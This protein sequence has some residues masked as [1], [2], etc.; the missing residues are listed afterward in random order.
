M[1]LNVTIEK[2]W[3]SIYESSVGIHLFTD[4]ITSIRL[5]GERHGGTTFLTAYLKECFPNRSIEDSFVSGKH[6]M[7]ASPKYIVKAAGK[8]GEAGL[9]PSQLRNNLNGKTWWQIA[10]AAKPESEFNTTLVLAVFRNPYDWI[11]AMR[12]GPWHWPNHIEILPRN[13]SILTTVGTHKNGT[14]PTNTGGSI[15]GETF[16]KSF[17][18]KSILEWKDF[19]SRPMHFLGAER[20]YTGGLCQKG[21][22]VGAI[23]PCYRDKPYTPTSVKHIPRSFLKHLPFAA[24]DVVYELAGKGTPYEHP[25]QLRAAKIKNFLGLVQKWELGGFG[26]VRYED[27]LGERLA[28]FVWS[29]SQA[30]GEESRC[31]QLLPFT[32]PRYAI[33][34]DFRTWITEHSDW[35]LESLIGYSPE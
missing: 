18:T 2:P 10:N 33:K 19:V 13:T 22:E 5:V 16:Q 1:L 14:E 26:L 29:I 17:V 27:L 30:F 8:Y 9:R 25:L 21:F 35:V 34:S 20:G 28:T 12:R 6:W 11:E 32:K 31:P 23:S 3:S 24:D 7:Q 4:K 15:R